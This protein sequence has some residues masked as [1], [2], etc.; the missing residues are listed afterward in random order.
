MKLFFCCLI[1]LRQSDKIIVKV[2]LEARNANN[3]IDISNK[4]RRDFQRIKHTFAE[5]KMFTY[6]NTNKNIKIILK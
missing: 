5:C 6:S 4:H 1:H 2:V 3:T